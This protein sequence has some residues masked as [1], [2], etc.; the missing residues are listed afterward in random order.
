M[1]APCEMPR[2]VAVLLMTA[3]L[4]YAPPP[5]A[6]ETPSISAP[7]A[8]GPINIDGRLDEPAWQ[9]ATVIPDLVQKEPHPGEPTPFHTKVLLLHDAHDIYI[10]FVCDDPEQALAVSHTMIRDG[11]QSYDDHVIIVLDT[12]GTRRVAYY[13]AIN[14]AGAMQDGL[15]TTTSN[16]T[17]DY[18]WDGVERVAT[19]QGDHGWTVEVAIDTR[20]LQ[21]SDKAVAWGFNLARYVP[22]VAMSSHWSGVTIDSNILDL[23]RLGILTGMNDVTQGQGWDFRPYG[24]AKSQSGSGSTSNSGFDVKYDFTPALAGQFTYH[25][26]FAE[27]EAD[28]EQINLTRFPVLFP[29][30]R[31]FFLEGSN[32]MSFGYNLFSNF[33]PFNSRTVGLVN[34]EPVPLDEGVKLLGQSGL[35]SV[36][37]LDTHM[38]STGATDTTNLLVSRETYNANDNLALGAMLT[39]GDPVGTSDNTFVGADALWK[40]AEFSGD[41]NLNI[42][43]WTGRVSGDL[44]AGMASGYGAGLEYPNDSWYIDEQI[45]VYGAALEPAMGFVP[46]PGTKQYYSELGYYPRPT[47]DTASWARQFLFDNWYSEV[48]GIDAGKQ[49]SELRLTPFGFTTTSGYTLYFP[50]YAEYD[51]P[52]A[53]FAVT[54]TVSVPPG[55]YGWHRYGANFN[56]P[57]SNNWVLTLNVSGGGY[58]AGRNQQFLAQLNWSTPSGR[59]LFT[60]SDQSVFGYLPQGDFY[61]RLATLSATY[62]FTPDIYVSSFAQYATGVPGVSWNL[63][64]RWIVES[65]SNIYL[66]W[67]RGL[68]TNTNGLGQPVVS[69]GNQFI[70]KVQWDF[71]A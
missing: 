66:V 23:H 67:N 46:R 30:K 40:T 50:L 62:S 39:H 24:I 3:A 56:T 1:H 53:P 29:E 7:L 71:R 28:Q 13:F 18:N 8:T 49:S 69:S 52:L 42:S 17:V 55:A 54:D 59:L 47:G 33:I 34:G 63:R 11:D 48:D 26:D 70:L 61:E 6:D 32:L 68:V 45:N 19:T 9:Q 35:G 14:P 12:F 36:A 21:F 5:R 20:S 60:A 64:L 44:P 2:L 58:Y 10:G 31:Q 16:A 65:T 37:L 41:K 15:L 57:Q 4:L 25:T 27:A 43:A 22:R 38:H 51:H